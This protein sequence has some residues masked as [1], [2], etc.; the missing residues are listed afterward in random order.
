MFSLSLFINLNGMDNPTGK[1]I[2]RFDQVRLKTT[3][4]VH[5][6]SAPPGTKT[7]PTGVWSVVAAVGVDLLLAQNNILV[8]IPVA[9]VLL[10]KTYN[11]DEITSNLGSLTSGKREKS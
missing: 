9:D 6:L 10:I 3:T 5:Y 1:K 2:G 4:N 7:S 8:R 11:I